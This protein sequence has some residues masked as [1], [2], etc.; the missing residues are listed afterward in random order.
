MNGGNIAFPNKKGQV[1]IPNQVRRELG[2]TEEIALK[3]SVW[4]PGMYVLPMSLRSKN[5]TYDDSLILEMLKKTQ[6]SW[7]P[8]TAEEK[9]IE[10]KRRSTTSCPRT[11]T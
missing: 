2:I 7:G 4:G 10:A 11:G 6:G 1:V 8:E 3:F 9:K 5:A